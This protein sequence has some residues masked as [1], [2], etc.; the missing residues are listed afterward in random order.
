MRKLESSRAPAAIGPYSHGIET[1]G[2]SFFSGQ[3][4]LDPESG[5]LVD[6]NFEAEVRQVMKNLQALLVDSGLGFGNVVKLNI[7][8]TDLSRFSEF[9]EIYAEY[10][11]E[12]Y[13]ARACVGVA[14]LPKGASLEI[15]MIATAE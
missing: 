12:P 5:T 10:L 7:S 1:R 8:M 3:I 6:S 14:S 13:P 2:L 4:G 15:E 9:N 11:K